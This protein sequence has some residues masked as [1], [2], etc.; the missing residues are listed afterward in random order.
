MKMPVFTWTALVTNIL[1]VAVFPVLT[2]V[3]ALLGLDR[4]PHQL[5]HQ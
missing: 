1:I 3:L 2:V 5:L 4:V